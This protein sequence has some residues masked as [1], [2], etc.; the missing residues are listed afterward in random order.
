MTGRRTQQLAPITFVADDG[1]RMLIRPIRPS[2][3]PLLQALHRRHSPET[4]RLRFFSAMPELAA[5]MA[6]QFAEVDFRTRAAFVAICE[7]EDEIRAVARYDALSEDTVE[8]AFVIEDHLQGKGLGSALFLTLAA[9]ATANGYT[10]LKAVTLAENL[11]MLRVFEHHAT[12]LDIR[13]VGSTLE[14]E[15]AADS[16]REHD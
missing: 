4:R 1:Q 16:I 2:D 9:H 6:T 11:P 15:M 14:V 3:A 5:P 12:I 10:R 13:R 8:V 7:G